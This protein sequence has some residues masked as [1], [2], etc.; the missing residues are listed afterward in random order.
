MRP[1]P[2]PL[3]EAESWRRSGQGRYE[4]S[5]REAHH[6]ARAYSGE[7]LGSSL[8]ALIRLR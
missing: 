3:M 1:A 5:R 4:V 7:D 6:P 8:R 2:F